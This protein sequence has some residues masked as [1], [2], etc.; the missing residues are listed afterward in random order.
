MNGF[1]ENRRRSH[2]ERPQN[3]PDLE[4]E[5]ASS[6]ISEPDY[7]ALLDDMF[8]TMAAISRPIALSCRALK[9]SGFRAGKTA[10]WAKLHAVRRLHATDYVIPALELIDA[11]CHNIVRKPSARAKCSTPFLITPPT[12]SD[13][14]RSSDQ[15]RRTGSALDLALMYRNGVIEE[16]GVAAGVLIIRQTAWPGWRTN[17]HPMTYNGSRANHSRWFV[18]PPGSGA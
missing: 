17:S 9:W 6:Q 7:G 8:S 1:D 2:A 4:S 3:R 5:Q 13:P 16:T 15:T 14:R 10:A 18:H 12:R 11:R